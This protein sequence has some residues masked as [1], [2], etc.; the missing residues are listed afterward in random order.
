[1]NL[2]S[3]DSSKKT[4]LLIHFNWM[5]NWRQ[6][7]FLFIG[8]L[9]LVLAYIAGL[10]AS[11]LWLSLCVLIFGII[12]LLGQPVYGLF[13]LIIVALIIPVQFGT[14]TAVPINLATLTVPSLLIIWL[15]YVLKEKSF[16]LVSSPVNRPLFIFLLTA[17]FSLVIGVVTWDTQVPRP[18]GFIIVQLAQWAIFAFSFTALALSSNLITEEVWLKRLTF[19]F[20][21]FAGSLAIIRVIPFTAHTAQ[22]IMT[23]AVHRAPFWV[24]LTALSGGQLLF[25]KSLSIY[26]RIFLLMIL[27]AALYF[28]FFILAERISH[29]SGIVIVLG[30]LLWLRFSKLKFIV[31]VIV[32]ILLLSGSL[33]PQ[34]YEFAGGDEKWD[35]SGGARLVLI[36]RV[37]E[38]TMRNPVTGLG[39]AAYRVY[40]GMQPLPYQ[41]AYWVAPQISSHNNYVDLF[42]H[43][44]ILGLIIFFWFVFEI[45]RMGNR[46]RHYY[47]SGFVAGYV[48]GMLAAGVGA[49]AVMMLA[50]WILPFVYNIAFRGFQ[51]SVL[52]WVFLGGLVALEN[53]A[54]RNTNYRNAK[55]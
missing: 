7:H 13:G 16:Q 44:G 47:T 15:I 17:I 9:T 52:I 5:Q 49:L 1:M 30:T 8:P 53:I 43:V 42:S 22:E 28:A 45:G 37:V 41:G 23:V 51:A 12:I 2:V 48:N 54:Q 55:S 36:E 27:G 29:W 19:F 46:L 39:P 6:W 34:L 35:E 50:D 10:H 20:L 21:L 4:T 40:A 33:L 32:G 14:G 18:T 3:G 26:W 31:P 25:N 38:V 24:L 11:F